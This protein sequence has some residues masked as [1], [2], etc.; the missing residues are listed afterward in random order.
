MYISHNLSIDPEHI[1]NGYFYARIINPSDSK[2]KLR[3]SK[4]G[5]NL[6]YDINSLGI[7]ET[8]P[9]QLGEGEYIVSLYK[10]VKK[11]NYIN[12]GT[13]KMY[14]VFEDSYQPYLNSNQYVDYDGKTNIIQTALEL[15]GKS[16][17]ETI[18]NIIDYICSNYYYDFVQAILRK[19]GQLPDISRCYEKKMGLCQDLAAL[20][21]ALLRINKVPARLVIGYYGAQ[22]HAWTE[23]IKN[24]KWELFDPTAEIRKD[25]KRKEYTTERW[26]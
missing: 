15:L 10:N 16:V 5:T 13:I 18:D 22:Y 14:P 4:N 2:Y 7:Q 11:K 17:E 21:V 3:V 8:F 6:T 12:E 24:D 9:L 26:Y 19:Q 25:K 1:A 23:I 20:T